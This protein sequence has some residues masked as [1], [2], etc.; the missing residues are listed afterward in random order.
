[1]P[2]ADG[3]RTLADDLGDLARECTAIVVAHLD[4]LIAR[5]PTIDEYI[6]AHDA[7]IN[8]LSRVVHMCQATMRDA[9]VLADNGFRPASELMLKLRLVELREER[10]KITLPGVQ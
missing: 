9:C 3:T 8:P 1:M 5:E 6:A 10:A 7:V 2:L 4:A